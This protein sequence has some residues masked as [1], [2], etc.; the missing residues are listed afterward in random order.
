MEMILGWFE[1]ISNAIT[2]NNI[3]DVLDGIV[4]FV[5]TGIKIWFPFDWTLIFKDLYMVKQS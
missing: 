4:V 3:P 5:D 1:Y 2:E